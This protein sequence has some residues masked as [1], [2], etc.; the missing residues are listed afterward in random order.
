VI[1]QPHVVQADGRILR[2]RADGPLEKVAGLPFIR[3]RRQ[4]IL[5]IGQGFG[6]I[7]L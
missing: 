2:V 5:Q 6:E 1:Q 3:F 4:H 7:G